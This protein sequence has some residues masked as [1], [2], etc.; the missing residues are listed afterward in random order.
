VQVSSKNRNFASVTKRIRIM[1][2][3][4]STLIKIA[5]VVIAICG[6]ILAKICIEY[7]RDYF[8]SKSTASE[9]TSYCEE[10]TSNLNSQCPFELDSWTTIQNVT[11]GDKLMDFKCVVDEDVIDA[12]SSDGYKIQ[13]MKIVKSQ[14]SKMEMIEFGR[15]LNK[16]EIE[17]RLLI[18]RSNGGIEN[19]VVI[20]GNDFIHPPV[21]I[22]EI[23]N[24]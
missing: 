23:I 1:S 24:R 7:T 16:A 8:S 2:K 3:T 17:M 15:K 22:S 5:S 21:D 4:K 19:T 11:M 10:L 13:L 14:M 18:Y 9:M 20:T 6:V 12:L